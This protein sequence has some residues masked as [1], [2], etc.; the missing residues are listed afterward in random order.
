MAGVTKQFLN[1]KGLGFECTGVFNEG[2]LLPLLM[3]DREIKVWNEKHRYKMQ[4]I[5]MDNR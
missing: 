1:A 5:Q 2:M 4:D 3:Y